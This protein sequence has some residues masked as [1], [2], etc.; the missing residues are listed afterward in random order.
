MTTE[1]SN[2][3]ATPTL[4]VARAAVQRGPSS[5]RF[6]GVLLATLLAVAL[7]GCATTGPGNASDQRIAAEMVAPTLQPPPVNH[8]PI[9]LATDESQ[10]EQPVKPELDVGTGNFINKKAARA[11]THGSEAPKGQVVFNFENEPIQAVVKAILGD[12]LQKNYIIAPGVNGNVTYATSQPVRTQDAMPILETLLSWTNNTL[13]FKNGRYT[14]LPTKAAIPGNLT[15][16]LAPAQ[17][18]KGYEVRIFPLHYIS[19]KEMQKL[20]KPFAPADAF[21]SVDTSRSLLIMAGTREQLE[22]YQRTI[23]IFDV[24][25]LKG[26]SV[27][28]YNMQNQD[29]A[30]LMPQLDAVFGA[31]GESPLAGMFRF[32]P[33]EA[34]NSVIVITSQPEYL[35]RAQ[36]WLKRLDAGAGSGSAQQIYIYDVKNVKAQDLAGYLNEIFNGISYT[37]VQDTGGGIAPGLTPVTASGSRFGR[38][39]S[40]NRQRQNQRRTPTRSASAG[41]T[42]TSGN[43]PRITAVESN[44]Q[45]LVLATPNQWDTI[46]QAARRLDIA[47]LQVQIEVK[48]LEVSLVGQFSFGVQWY[49]EGLIGSSGGPE[50]YSQPGNKQAWALGGTNPV[51]PGKSDSFFYSFVNSELQAAIHAME[52]SGNTK[53]LSQPSLVVLNNQEASID[54]GTQIPV[55]Q[56][57]FTPGGYG[58]GAGVNNGG[59]QTGSVSYLDTG[60]QLQVTPRVNPGGLVYMEID[61]E[62]SQP[63]AIVSVSGNP[64]IDKRS[65]QTQVAVQSGQTVLLGGLIKQNDSLTDT[66]VPF[67]SRIPIVG[68]LFGTTSHNSNRVELLVLITPRVI[69][70][71]AE[72]QEI[73]REYQLRFQSLKPMRDQIQRQDAATRAQQA[74]AQ[75]PPPPPAQQPPAQP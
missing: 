65:I 61:Q 8:N 32:V 70:N 22:N 67:L 28:V 68:K 25:W 46:Q 35:D 39:N 49:L 55:I 57:Y 58:A 27:G 42:A 14:V 2:P 1:Q 36:E 40:M 18:A 75:Q 47:P 3:A 29:V 10:S 4:A 31:K 45:L 24:D 34:T 38:T 74:A 21:V 20:L 60:I 13:I 23:D 66:G 54:V 33:I 41:A 12:L 50:G 72:A 44:N 64:P 5:W 37:P 63:G 19:P 7:S 15:P 71:S 17:V 9:S 73:T 30:K 48:I 43:G 62:V 53:T 69:T 11:P 56:N 52:S 59:Y 6:A 26:M 51:S 16:R